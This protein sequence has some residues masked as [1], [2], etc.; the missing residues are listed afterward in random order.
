[1]ND[2][3]KIIELVARRVVLHYSNCRISESLLLAIRRDITLSLQNEIDIRIFP[4]HI[5]ETA[6][7]NDGIFTIAGLHIKDGDKII[8]KLDIKYEK[9]TSHIEFIVTPSREPYSLGLINFM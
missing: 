4:W 6:T 8:F 9:G 2:F 5:E 3:L 1:M 7:E